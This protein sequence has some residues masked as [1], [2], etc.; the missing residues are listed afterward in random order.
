MEGVTTLGSIMSDF[1]DVTSPGQ[2]RRM[3]IS[4]EEEDAPMPC[5][6]SGPMYYLSKSYEEVLDNYTTLHEKQA[7]PTCTHEKT[8]MIFY[9]SPNL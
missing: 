4:P 2:I 5:L 6:F 9:W 7:A 1:P 8:S 3:R